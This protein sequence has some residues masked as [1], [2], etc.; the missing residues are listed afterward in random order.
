MD[1]H[2]DGKKDTAPEQLF[3]GRAASF[4]EFIV[5]I[6]HFMGV[7]GSGDQTV[8]QHGDEHS[9]KE[10]ACTAQTAHSFAPQFPQFGM[11]FAQHFKKGD[12]DHNACRK[13]QCT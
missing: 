4:L 10:S 9:G 7:L 6:L 13:P 8:D 11:G 1:R 3:S 12:I 5:H 2:G